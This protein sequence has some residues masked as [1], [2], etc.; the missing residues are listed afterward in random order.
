MSLYKTMNLQ[1]YDMENRNEEKDY[2][3]CVL[4]GENKIIYSDTFEIFLD[5]FFR[6][7]FKLVTSLNLIFIDIFRYFFP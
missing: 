2:F 7:I 6:D 1:I 4:Y 3:E 5:I